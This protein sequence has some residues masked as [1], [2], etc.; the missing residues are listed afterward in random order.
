MS[1]YDEHTH[2]YG[3]EFIDK[4]LEKMTPFT[5]D[6]LKRLIQAD[7]SNELCFFQ[8]RVPDL[9]HRLEA[10]EAIIDYGVHETLPMELLNAWLRAKGERG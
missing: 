10:A 3:G 2:L 9:L 1:E 7:C 5:D 6:D 4:E 8:K